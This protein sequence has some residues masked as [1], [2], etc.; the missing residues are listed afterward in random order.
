M[1]KFASKN[2]NKNSNNK[3]NHSISHNTNPNEEV[4]IYF[5][6]IS[7]QV[8]QSILHGTPCLNKK[9]NQNKTKKEQIQ[10]EKYFCSETPKTIIYG[11]TSILEIHNNQL[12][13]IYPSDKMVL[14]SSIPMSSAS[15]ASSASSTKQLHL[16]VDYS[17]MKRSQSQCYQIPYEFKVHSRIVKKYKINPKSNT[18]FVIE[19]KDNKIYDFYILAKL[20]RVPI[21][22]PT[23]RIELDNFIKEDIISF[24]LMLNLY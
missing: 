8:L 12:Y 1:H 5:P 10:L 3:T 16:L 19:Y 15:S 13:S 7:I 9:E 22:I 2:G 11:T 4:K 24:L 18:C 17:T 21:G 6:S 20:S 14:T 23:N